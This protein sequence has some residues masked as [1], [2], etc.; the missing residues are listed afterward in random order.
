MAGVFPKSKW[1][2]LR[3]AV[4]LAVLAGILTW[5]LFIPGV[6]YLRYAPEEGDVVF[7]SLPHMDL[8]DTIEGV[9]GS[10]YSH[11][12]VVIREN[13][14]WL[15]A[16]SIGEVRKTPLF[17]WIRRG[18][19]CGRFAAYRL[20]AEHRGSIPRF[21]EALEPFMGRPY[22][23]RY[24][25]DDDTLYCS[26]LVYKAWKNA[27]GRELGVLRKLGDMN[28]QPWEETLRKYED[29]EPPLQRWMITPRDLSEAPEL[30]KVFGGDF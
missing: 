7:Q 3:F 29:G 5:L 16:E 21:I 11:C 17:G 26:E 19:G 23:T 27:T 13:G 9:T 20:R 14:E 28:W 18:R 10:P 8:V 12:G 22:D 30:E 24:E 1:G 15:V 25:M 4:I 2:R 6:R